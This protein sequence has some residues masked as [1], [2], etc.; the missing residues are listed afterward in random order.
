L[1]LLNHHDPFFSTRKNR[2]EGRAGCR[3]AG[4]RLLVCSTDAIKSPRSAQIVLPAGHGRGV[5]DLMVGMGRKAVAREA[6][7]MVRTVLGWI[8][9]QWQGT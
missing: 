2:G 1:S 5:V 7:S 4:L 9:R 3:N 8:S 6:F